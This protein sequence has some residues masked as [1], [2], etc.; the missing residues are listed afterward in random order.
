MTNNKTSLILLVSLIFGYCSESL[1]APSISRISQGATEVTIVGAGFGSHANYGGGQAFLNRAWN[2]FESGSFDKGNMEVSDPRVWR[3]MSSQNRPGSNYYAEKFYNDSVP[4]GYGE[5]GALQIT[6]TG[7]P[8]Q[9]Y[10]SFWF[11]LLQNNQSGKFWRIYG[12]SLSQNI[13]L[14]TGGGDFMIR[15]FSEWGGETQWD[16]P[17][18]FVPG[19]WHRVEILMNDSPS[20]FR[21]WM[22]GKLQFTRTDWVRSPF[23]GDGHS[24]DIGNMIDGPDRGMAAVG[25]YGYDDVFV[26]HTQGRVELGNSA[27]WSSSTIREIQ[28]PT[29]WLNGSVTVTLNRG[30]FGSG[31]YYLFV[32]DGAGDTSNGFP[33][34]IGAPGELIPPGNL[35]MI[36]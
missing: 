18:S 10:V 24:I 6:Q 36:K 25:G 32:V 5:L 14:A 4:N 27:T 29:S 8:H 31:T 34:T 19:V 3:M 11:K 26:D 21:V 16:S 20:F 17:D 9:W 35:R 12:D 2:N 33:I 15:G 23:N 13:Y 22:N 7:S 1:G 30:G 28:V